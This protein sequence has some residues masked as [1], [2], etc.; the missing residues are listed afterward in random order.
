[1]F[2]DGPYYSRDIV[3]RLLAL[4]ETSFYSDAMAYTNLY[5]AV[6]LYDDASLVILRSPMVSPEYEEVII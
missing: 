1:M 5:Q 6:R 3:V 4:A 2:D